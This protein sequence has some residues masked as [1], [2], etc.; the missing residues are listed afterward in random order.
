MDEFL[1]A[2]RALVGS[3]YLL[4]DQ[5]D[6]LPY[7]TEWRQRV[8][9]KALAVILP[10]TTAEVAAI[11]VLCGRFGVAIVPQG[12][13]TGLVLGSIP[14]QSGSAI[15]LSLKRM[16]AIR[17]IDS[18]NNTMIVEAGCLLEHVQQAAAAAG[19]LYP[20]ALASQGNCTIGGNLAT[21]AGGTAVLRYGNARELC[22]GLE[23]VNADGSIWHGLKALRKDNTGYDLRDLFIGAEGTLGIITAAVLKLYPQARSSSTVLLALATPSDALAMLNL[24]RSTLGATLS[25]FELIADFCLTLVEKHFPSLHTPFAQRHPYY[26]LLEISDHQAQ[27]QAGH[28]IEALLELAL[29]QGL[30]ADAVLA[31]SI[32]QARNLWALREN[33]SLAQGTEGKNIKHDISLPISE[34]PAFIEYMATCLEQ[35]YP[36][37]RTVC[38][39]HMGDGNLHY[40]ISAPEHVDKQDWLT[41]QAAIN[42]LVHDQVDR[43]HGSISAEH[44]LGSLKRE[45]IKRY[46]S[47]TELAL[48]RAIKMALDPQNLMNPGK[49]L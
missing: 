8:R 38:F 29:A 21:N 37:C 5:V 19:R 17:A 30:I 13:N 36:G 28:A 6:V 10:A 11:V 45:E 9:G 7:E 1:S 15:I 20:L 26:V 2:C 22:L 41:Q 34:I 31:S 16:H 3:N 44:G 24:A 27:P 49:V 4:R 25:G 32:A 23:V 12:G 39:G 42:R 40:N 46:K 48:M 14:D 18:V 33:I 35:H 47:D 43:M